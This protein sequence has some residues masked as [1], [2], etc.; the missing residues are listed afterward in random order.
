MTNQARPSARCRKL[1]LQLSRYLD[2]DLTPARRLAVQRH[3]AACE[4]CATLEARLRRTV[5]AC[6]AEGARRPPRA[7][8]SRAA[9]R[10]RTL[11]ARG[12]PA[13]QKDA[14]P[15]ATS[16]TP[17]SGGHAAR[18]RARATRTR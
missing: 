9:E 17:G 8:V 11:M 18:A 15:R 7:V 2:D 13:P 10:I 1:L 16:S 5:A 3:V 12:A 4:C 6:Q 14:S